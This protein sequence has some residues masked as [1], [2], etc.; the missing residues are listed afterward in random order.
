MRLVGNRGRVVGNTDIGIAERNAAGA[1]QQGRPVCL[2]HRAGNHAT[3][4]NRAIIGAGQG[5]GDGLGQEATAGL[6]QNAHCEGFGQRFAQ[7]QR[8]QI[9]VVGVDAIGPDQS[10]FRRRRV[11]QRGDLREGSAPLA[12]VGR[13]QRQPLI[14]QQLHGVGRQIGVREGKAAGVGQRGRGGDAFG[15]FRNRARHFGHRA[16]CHRVIGARQGQR[17]R[18]AG[19]AAVAVVQRDRKGQR[20]LLRFP[21]EVHGSLGRRKAPRNV[22]GVR[23]THA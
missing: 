18:L 15:K 12:G 19:A 14:V 6:V 22:P 5:D 20:R 7:A 9:G 21:Q 2:N 13:V 4:D 16:Q 10:L 3:R 23:R 8:L 11:C 17:D 1:F